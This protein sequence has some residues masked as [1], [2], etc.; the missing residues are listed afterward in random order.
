MAVPGDGKRPLSR[1]PDIGVAIERPRFDDPARH[2]QAAGHM[3]VEAFVAEAAVE[4][5]DKRVLDRLARRDVVPSDAA[6]FLLAQ[7]G[8]R[9]QLGAVVANNHQRL[10]RAATMASSSR[11]TR[12]AG[13][14]GVDDQRQA[15]AGE[16][17]DNNEHPEPAAIGQH[18]GDE[19]EAPALVGTL[20]QSHWRSRAE[21]PFATVSRSSR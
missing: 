9:G 16:V 12:P 10:L 14:R 20:W 1:G 18:I 2:R 15:F 19:V 17:V 11:A 6:F 7:H 21:G 4:A 13:D 3:L 8:V 5:F